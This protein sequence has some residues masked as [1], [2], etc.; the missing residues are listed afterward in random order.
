[1]TESTGK[2]RV[3]AE[4]GWIFVGRSRTERRPADLERPPSWRFN[5]H[6]GETWLTVADSDLPVHR[7]VGEFFPFPALSLFR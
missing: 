1:M 6:L 5:S 3:R 4:E 7:L 2:G